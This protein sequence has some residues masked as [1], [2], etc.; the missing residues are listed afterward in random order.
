MNS[1]DSWVILATFAW[2]QEALLLRNRLEGSGIAALIPEEHIASIDPMATGMRVTVLVKAA[3]AE[4]ARE[5]LDLRP[6]PC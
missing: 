3:E 6:G 4:R 2:L 1:D 5:V